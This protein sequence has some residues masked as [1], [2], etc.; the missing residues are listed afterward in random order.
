MCH[1][2]FFLDFKKYAADGQRT[3]GDIYRKYKNVNAIYFSSLNFGSRFRWWWWGRWPWRPAPSPYSSPRRSASN[4]RVNSSKTFVDII[5]RWSLLLE[6]TTQGISISNHYTQF[7]FCRHDGGRHQHWQE[8]EQKTHDVHL[9]QERQ[10]DVLWRGAELNKYL[11]MI[12][13]L[14]YSYNLSFYKT[15]KWL[16]TFIIK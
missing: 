6:I 13:Y 2:V 15:E 10:A 16:K 9:A 11:R 12:L 8:L 1:P 5:Y 7:F 4:C 3:V 14:L